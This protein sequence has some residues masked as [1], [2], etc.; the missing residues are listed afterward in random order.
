MNATTLTLLRLVSTHATY[1]ALK[2][3]YCTGRNL[4]AIPPGNVEWFEPETDELRAK[5]G[6]A[7]WDEAAP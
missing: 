1:G 4:Q 7:P 3:S 2:A 5:Y 6:L